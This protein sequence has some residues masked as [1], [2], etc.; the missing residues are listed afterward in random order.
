MALITFTGYP[1]SGKSQRASQLK[2][3]LESRFQSLEYEGP[4]LKVVLISD[5]TLNLSRNAYNG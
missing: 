5:D 4:Q 2:S 1:C 3:Y